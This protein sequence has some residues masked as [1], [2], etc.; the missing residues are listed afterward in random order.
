MCVGAGEGEGVDAESLRTANVYA[1][2]AGEF[3]YVGVGRECKWGR[4]ASLWRTRRKSKS[5]PPWRREGEK[6]IACQRL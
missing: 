6:R 5:L 2:K 3:V 1:A 4:K